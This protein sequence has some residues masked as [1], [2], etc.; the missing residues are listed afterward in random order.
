MQPVERLAPVERRHD[1]VALLAQRVGQQLLDRQLV[2]DE[3]DPR[4]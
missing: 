4:C 2:V 1:V 3:K